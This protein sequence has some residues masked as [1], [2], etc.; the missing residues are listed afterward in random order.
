M[1]SSTK[2]TTDA[3]TIVVVEV[4]PSWEEDCM[5]LATG[6]TGVGS[7]APVEGGVG[8]SGGVGVPPVGRA[9]VPVLG[10][11][12]LVL[13]LQEPRVA[14][15]EA[16]EVPPLRDAVS[17]PPSD[18]LDVS[19]GLIVAARDIVGVVAALS[20]GAA[21]TVV[22]S[23]AVGAG[24]IVTE[25]VALTEALWVAVAISVAVEVPLSLLVAVSVML[26]LSAGDLV[27]VCVVEAE[28]DIVPD[29]VGVAEDGGVKD[30]V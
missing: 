9:P 30:A 28:T 1:R 14:V 12:W 17:V 15:A 26:G 8:G 10:W 19:D 13:M 6:G 21:V 24:E 11:D 20:L 29:T 3:T 4:V 23:D 5:V 25:S 16:E 22:V 27:T 18:A 7:V 2:G